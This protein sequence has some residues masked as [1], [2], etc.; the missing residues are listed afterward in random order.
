[1]H[2]IYCEFQRDRPIV[3]DKARFEVKLVGFSCSFKCG[4]P[5][6]LLYIFKMKKPVSCYSDT[7]EYYEKFVVSSGIRKPIEQNNMKLGFDITEDGSDC[8]YRMTIAGNT[9]V[10]QK[11]N[12]PS[13]LRFVC[14]RI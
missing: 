7:A 2:K 12:D 6:R 9:C 11:Q 10:F 1:M 14:L 4:Y 5:A 3:Q 13:K 8:R